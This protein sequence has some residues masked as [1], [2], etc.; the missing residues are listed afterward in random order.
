MPIAERVPA[1][2]VVPLRTAVLR[3]GW[4]DRLATYP[5]DDNAATVHVAA[6]HDGEVAAVGTAYPEAPPAA[7]RG[8]IPEA[9]FAGGAAWRLRGMASAESVRGAGYGAA[10]LR[11]CFDAI[12][13]A[14]GRY[15]WCNARLVAV[16]F[17]ERMGMQ[18]VGDVFDIA[19]IGPHYVMW[20]R[21]GAGT[22][23]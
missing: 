7:L 4:T 2:A 9:A 17:Y 16:P 1:Y 13:D 18:T 22:R 21:V 14:R 12:A 8:A 3:P 15:L 10:V 23:A 6:F 20:T 11:A 19:E 5:E